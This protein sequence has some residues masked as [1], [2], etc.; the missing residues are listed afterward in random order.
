M[1]RFLAVAVML[2]VAATLSSADKC[3]KKCDKPANDITEM[4]FILDRSGSMGGLESDTIGGFNSMIKEQKGKKGEAYVTT[5]LFDNKVETLHNRLPIKKVKPIT[6]KDYFVRGTTALLDAVGSAVA[7]VDAARKDMA[8]K[9][10]P[11]HTVFVI[12]TDGLENASREYT[13]K[14]VKSVIE[15][16]KK[17]GWEF[18]FI[19]ANMDAV[20]AAGRIGIDRENAVNYV[21]DGTGI[22]NVYGGVSK[23]LEATRNGD[24]ASPEWREDI[25]NDYNNR[26]K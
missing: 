16:H 1:K 19:G 14:A 15:K 20:E 22:K 9:D 13:A 18:V 7:K 2:C 26:G 8:K 24:A 11:A 21:N 4:V 10:I 5:I 6:E 3:P 12:T 17:E 23:K 25:D